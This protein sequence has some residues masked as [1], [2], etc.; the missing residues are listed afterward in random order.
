MGGNE[1]WVDCE[2][3]ETLAVLSPEGAVLGIEDTGAV[4]DVEQAIIDKKTTAGKNMN[5]NCFF[6]TQL[7]STIK[8]ATSLT[9]KSCGVASIIILSYEHP[10]CLQ[11]LVCDLRF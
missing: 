10:R 4:G 8:R 2:L 3:D 9:A 7:L 1:G 5:L 11:R 6:I